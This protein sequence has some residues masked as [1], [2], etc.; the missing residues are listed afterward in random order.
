M[1]KEN[2]NDAFQSQA[3]LVP[4]APHFGRSEEFRALLARAQHRDELI[5]VRGEEVEDFA[6]PLSAVDLQSYITQ[7]Y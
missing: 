1:S 7:L 3:L 5:L 4:N 2:G 6:R